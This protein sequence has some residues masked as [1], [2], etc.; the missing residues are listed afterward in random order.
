MTEPTVRQSTSGTTTSDQTSITLSFGAPTLSTSKLVVVIGLLNASYP[1][2]PSGWT[3]IN[4]ATGANWGNGSPLATFR[5]NGDGN[6]SYTFPLPGG[7]YYG[8]IVTA[9]LAEVVDAGDPVSATAHFDQGPTFY[10]APLS[11]PVKSSIGGGLGI[12][13][14]FNFSAPGGYPSP[15]TPFGGASSGVGLSGGVYGGMYV[16][17]CTISPGCGIY[18]QDFTYSPVNSSNNNA[19]LVVIVFPPATG[20]TS[21]VVVNAGTVTVAAN[22]QS[23]PVE[24]FCPQTPGD[25]LIAIVGVQGGSDLT[26]DT[27]DGWTLIG[28]TAGT[29]GSNNPYMAAFSKEIPFPSGI[30]TFTWGPP[31]VGGSYSSFAVIYEVPGGMTAIATNYVDASPITVGPV[32]YDNSLIIC[33]IL[34]FYPGGGSITFD[35]DGSTPSSG[36]AVDTFQVGNP[37]GGMATFSVYEPGSGDA[38]FEA[39]YDDSFYNQWS[40]AILIAVSASASPPPTPPVGDPPVGGY[41]AWYDASQIVEVADGD[42]L[43]TW[44]DL[45]GN[46][47][48]L[49]SARYAAPTYYSKT[50]EYL[51]NGL[52]IVRTG[53]VGRGMECSSFPNLSE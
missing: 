2:T 46:G 39:G 37:Y 34:W 50:S 7:G 31:V 33:G 48:D 45:S 20:G 4:E 16:S 3:L 36:W 15:K 17:T 25:T 1:P 9:W 40:V 5:R 11:A 24:M 12:A 22:V 35:S 44:A 27:P 51:V 29:L 10:G 13:A 32:A 14:C 47:Y 49:S 8:Y 53:E 28:T 52:P 30:Y 6:S 43:A 18:V 19:A 42:S 23:L 38:T 26:I 41:I 21:P